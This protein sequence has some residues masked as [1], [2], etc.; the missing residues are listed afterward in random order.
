MN[1]D[2]I[3]KSFKNN[4]FLFFIVVLFV[5]FIYYVAKKMATQKINCQN[6]INT[7]GGEY[8][9]SYSFEELNQ[10]KYFTTTINHNNKKIS[11]DCKLKDFYI[12]TAHNCCVSG[13]YKN[14]FVD[15]CALNNCATYNVRALDFQVYSL[16]SKPIV[17]CSSI[18]T[19]FYKE[20]YNNIP[21]IDTME[22]V[23]QLYFNSNNYDEYGFKT[24]FNNQSQNDPLF[25]I[26][27]LHYGTNSNNGNYTDNKKQFYNQIYDILTESFDNSKFNAIQMTSVYGSQFKN[28]RNQIVPNIPMNQL[29][30]R[31]F[32]FIV[33]NDDTDTSIIKTTK[34]DNIVDLYQEE[35]LGFK[36]YDIKQLNSENNFKVGLE[37]KN[38]LVF[39]KP[40]LSVYSNNPNFIDQVSNGIQFIG[41][42]FQTP[43]NNLKLYNDFFVNQY[44]GSLRYT[45]DTVNI[46][47]C[48][49]IKK[50]DNMISLP[51]GYNIFG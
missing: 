17:A 12:K 42:N 36:T 44:G 50:P 8:N 19:N 51:V 9:E 13:K 33:L 37:T 30:K 23:N 14:D 22:R 1:S 18:N 15:L 49:Y 21:L 46:V 31:I 41:M 25:L 45:N 16:N 40:N 34:L 24:Q 38:T 3:Q 11:Y 26:F 29:S 20:S 43:D 5:I 35:T 7:R 4:Y 39:S 32:V 2:Y 48:P 10:M 47:T 27:R 6:I 28:E